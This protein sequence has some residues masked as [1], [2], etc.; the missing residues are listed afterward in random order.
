MSRYTL[1]LK[2]CPTFMF[3]FLQ[4]PKNKKKTY[5]YIFSPSL[6]IDKTFEIEYRYLT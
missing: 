3:L 5:K 4:N 2:Y 6:P 1:C